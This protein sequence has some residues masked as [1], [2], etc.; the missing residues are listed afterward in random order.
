[1]LFCRVLYIKAQRTLME[2]VGEKLFLKIL[3]TL[4]GITV[5]VFG[6]LINTYDRMSS[7]RR[8]CNQFSIEDYQIIFQY[9]VNKKKTLSRIFDDLFN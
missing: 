9:Q 6:V 7:S 1:M 5:A 8:L 2:N 4:G 3:I